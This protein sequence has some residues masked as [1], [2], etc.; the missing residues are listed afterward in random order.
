M[1][2]LRATCRLQ[3]GL[4]NSGSFIRYAAIFPGKRATSFAP[5]ASSTTNNKPI[6]K[7]PCRS[8][9]AVPKPMPIGS[10]A[11]TSNPDYADNF[12]RMKALVDQ[13]KTHVNRIIL[14]G[15]Q[16]AR[17]RHTSRGKL[18][19]R[20]RIDRLLDPGS[21]FLEFSQL[22]AFGVYGKEDVPCAGIITG[23]KELVD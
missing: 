3:L 11:E 19:A 23:I 13:L 5:L 12:D 4:V 2:S 1:P 17:D 16:R 9:N 6:L 8:F 10:P 21:P 22:A 14:G 15:D 20:D 7:V 18:L